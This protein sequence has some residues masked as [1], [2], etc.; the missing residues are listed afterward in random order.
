MS[1]HCRLSTE[2]QDLHL[3]YFKNPGRSE[4]MDFSC[5]DTGAT[6]I[7][8]LCMLTDVTFLLHQISS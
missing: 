2:T 6:T 5:Y 7:I 8:Q 1:A 3:A 4:C